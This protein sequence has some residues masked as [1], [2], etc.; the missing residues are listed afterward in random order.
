MREAYL[1]RLT[2]LVARIRKQA[3]EQPPE[4]RCLYEA[5]VARIKCKSRITK[6]PKKERL[7]P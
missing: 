6:R 3:H 1:F 2:Y 5:D 7:Q 4:G